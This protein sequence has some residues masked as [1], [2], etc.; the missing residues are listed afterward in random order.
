MKNCC[1]NHTVH[2]FS[3]NTCIIFATIITA[4][5]MFSLQANSYKYT[6]H[7]FKS[8]C[9]LFF[10][11]HGPMAS[12]H[13]SCDVHNSVE[14]FQ[15]ASIPPVGEYSTVF[16]SSGSSLLCSQKLATSHGADPDKHQL[17]IANCVSLI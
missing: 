6:S 12:I 11:L 5:S 13:V 15:E 1:P 3:G 9:R 17:K 4:F 14:S 10:Y 2:M 8:H 7:L 16:V